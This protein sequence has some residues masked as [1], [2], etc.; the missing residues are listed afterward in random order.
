MNLS[1]LCWEAWDWVKEAWMLVVVV[2]GLLLFLAGATYNH[3]ANQQA[4]T[5]FNPIHLLPLSG[6]GRPVQ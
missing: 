4:G 1:K 2:V 6:F 3:R 5:C